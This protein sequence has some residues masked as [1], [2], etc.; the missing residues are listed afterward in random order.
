MNTLLG[1]IRVLAEQ[2]HDVVARWQLRGWGSKGELDHALRGLRR[3]HSGVCALGELGELGWYMAAALAGGPA[4]AISHLSALMLMGLRPTR[5]GDIHVTT[6]RRGGPAQ[7][8]GIIPHRPRQAPELWAFRNVP[9]TS[10]TQSLLDAELKPH[11]L[12]RALEQ[13]EKRHIPVS[14]PPSEITALKQRVTGYTRSDTEAAF[15]LLCHDNGLPLPLVNQYLNGFETDF[16][17]P[18]LRLVVEVDGFEHHRERPNFNTDR[19]RG[20]VHRANGYE[21]VRISADHVYD[22]TALILRAL[23]LSA[24]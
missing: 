14:L 17:W 22:Q 11:E 23:P 6:P 1:R 3:V 7:R 10:P 21:V 16:H 8:D 19:Y 13:A 24:G 20:L 9:V 15:L 18:Q 5:P 4:A 12:Y 2:Q